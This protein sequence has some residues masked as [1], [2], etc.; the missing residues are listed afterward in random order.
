MAFERYVLASVNKIILVGDCGRDPDMRCLPPICHVSSSRRS[1][2]ETSAT[3]PAQEGLYE[4]F[5]ASRYLSSQWFCSVNVVSR[6]P[7]S[8]REKDFDQRSSGGKVP[9]GNFDAFRS[10]S[11]FGSTKANKRNAP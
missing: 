1:N 10:G 11:F 2:A 5:L 7:T 3:Q 6:T 4:H 9:V 8:L